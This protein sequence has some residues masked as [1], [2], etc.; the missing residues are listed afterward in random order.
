MD[1]ATDQPGAD[2][3][4][5][6]Q[7]LLPSIETAQCLQY[8]TAGPLRAR[9]GRHPIGHRAVSACCLTSD[10]MDGKVRELI[11]VPR[12]QQGVLLVTGNATRVL[13]KGKVDV[14]A[15]RYGLVPASRA[16][17]FVRHYEPMNR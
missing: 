4:V 10:L 17:S 5:L 1:V 13:R 15:P 14:S 12:D 3:P 8:R 7:G 2:P 6:Q 11:K 16:P 9:A